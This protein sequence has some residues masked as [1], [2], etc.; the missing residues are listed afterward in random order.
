M[1]ERK[2]LTKYYPPDFDPSLVGRSRKPKSTGPKVQTVRLMAPF[3][4]R[5]IKCGEYMYRG[6]KFNARKETP[7]GEKYLGI[8][9]Y[10]FYI[11]CTRCSAEIV[12]RTDPK[13]QDY[14]VERGAKRNTEPWKRGLGENGEEETDEQR[15]DRLERELAEREGRAAE[16]K[17]AMEELEAKTAEAK[18]EM[19]VAD[20]LDEIRQR[21]ER[22]DRARREREGVF[23]GEDG[24]AFLVPGGRDEEER[25]RKEEEEDAE[26]ARRA[27]AWA[28]RHEALEEVIVEDGEE[29]T[30]ENGEGSGTSSETVASPAVGGTLT[31]SATVA[32]TMPAPSFKRQVKKKKDHSALLGIKKKPLVAYGSDEDD[33]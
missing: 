15:L 10:R 2:V 26:A 23:D 19:E 3:S 24:S 18:R 31:P 7:P 16:E 6:R 11:R 17:N 4:L 14:M 9:I 5:C 20:M 1:S 33:D 25:R 29:A 32:D 13:N 12:F 22:L 21:N 8:Q 27:F 30:G 28:R